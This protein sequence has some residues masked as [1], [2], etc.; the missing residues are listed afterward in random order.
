MR[1]AFIV[2]EFPALSET[3]ILNQIMGLIDRGHEVDIYA[4]NYG[5]KWKTC[6]EIREYCLLNRT[7]YTQNPSN[8]L[9]RVRA[10][11]FFIRLLFTIYVKAPFALLHILNFLKYQWGMSKKWYYTVEFFLRN[12]Q[13]DIIH[14]QFGQLGLIV[15][16]LA[17]MLGIRS[18]F[19]TSFRGYDI[20][21]YVKKFGKDIYNKLF[22]KGDLFLPNCGYFKNRL[23]YLGCDKTKITIHRSGIDC[24]KFFSTQKHRKPNKLIRIVSVGRLVEKKGI[25]YGIYAIKKLK[26]VHQNIKYDIIGNGP[27]KDDLNQLIEKLEMGETISLLGDKHQKEVIKI[28]NNSHI[29]ITPSVTA[30]TGDQEGIPNIVKEAMAMN[31]PVI[32][33]NHSGIPE[34]IKN[35]I[36]GILV[37]ERDIDALAEK[38]D[39]LIN[40]PQIWSNMCKAARSHVVEH[41]DINKLND[42][43]VGIYK[44]VLD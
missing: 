40:N 23:N 4:L 2:N 33:T 16:L 32:G 24:N 34:L 11:L 30:N 5:N 37:P 21:E 44:Q 3:F 42:R 6:P 38:L 27:L 9:M 14:C 36:S 43:L 35:G 26:N 29:L 12:K 20:S 18:K 19:I 39:Y 15:I 13:Y 17:R 7:Y 28:L 1:I 10:F 22:D 25:K 31:L 41:Y 8:F